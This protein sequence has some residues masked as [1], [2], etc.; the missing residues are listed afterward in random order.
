MCKVSHAVLLRQY[1]DVSKPIPKV[2][3]A[4]ESQTVIYHKYGKP[5][6]TKKGYAG[7]T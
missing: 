3:Y 2:R 7:E 1:H 5:N 4:T 6:T